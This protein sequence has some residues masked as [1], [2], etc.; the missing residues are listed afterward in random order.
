MEQVDELAEIM[1]DAEGDHATLVARL[2]AS[3][4]IRPDDTIEL[5]VDLRK[6]HFFD[7]AS[8]AAIGAEPS[9]AG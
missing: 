1:P 8:G 3:A 2:D 5:A 7:I 6:L 4:Q 9:A